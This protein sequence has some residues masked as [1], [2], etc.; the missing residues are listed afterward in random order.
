M[1]KEE[2]VPV[3]MKILQSIDELLVDGPEVEIDPE[4]DAWSFAAPPPRGV[5]DMKLFKAKDGLQCGWTKEGDDSTLFVTCKLECKLV[6]SKDEEYDGQM[7][8]ASVNTKVWRG[9]HISKMAGLI[10]KA[11]YK[12][13]TSLSPRKCGK[14]FE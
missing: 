10:V 8:F 4:E 13:P 9:K 6:N 2:Y 1:P 14:L 3:K 7:V 5:Y 11:G 12:V